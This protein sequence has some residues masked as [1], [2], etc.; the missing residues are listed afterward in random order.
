MIVFLFGTDKQFLQYSKIID[1]EDKCR[2]T[3]DIHLLKQLCVLTLRILYSLIMG[4]VVRI[5]K[6]TWTYHMNLPQKNYIMTIQKLS[7]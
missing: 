7:Q 1:N 4:R 5:N 6:Q 2:K 3:V